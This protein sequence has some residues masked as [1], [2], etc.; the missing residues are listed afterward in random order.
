M[1]LT[2]EQ[3]VEMYCRVLRIRRFDEKPTC[4]LQGLA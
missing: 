1:D 2:R 3:L 4:G